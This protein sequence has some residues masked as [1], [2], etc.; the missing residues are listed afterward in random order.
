M[1]LQSR[2]F[3]FLLYWSH[4]HGRLS[5]FKYLCLQRSIIL[6]FVMFLLHC[7]K[8][9]ISF[10]YC[11]AIVYSLHHSPSI[12]CHN[13]DICVWQKTCVKKWTSCFLSPYMTRYWYSSK[14]RKPLIYFISRDLYQWALI[15]WTVFCPL[16]S[17]SPIGPRTRQFCPGPLHLK[18]FPNIFLSHC[19]NE[20]YEIGIL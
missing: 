11:T 16:V 13:I 6:L 20:S 15:A 17:P 5:L 2:I 1:D 7:H 19:K 9:E 18:V 3:V 14:N 8:T 4:G 10:I 12:Y